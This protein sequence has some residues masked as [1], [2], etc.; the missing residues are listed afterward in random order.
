MLLNDWFS[1]L[2]VAPKRLVSNAF[3]KRLGL[4]VGHSFLSIPSITRKERG[5]GRR[6]PE[7]AREDRISLLRVREEDRE[8]GETQRRPER[9]RSLYYA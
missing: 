2:F 3:R 4:G 6:G 9:T 7:E 8:E 5:R 1:M